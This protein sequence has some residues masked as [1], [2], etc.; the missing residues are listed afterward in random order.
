MIPRDFIYKYMFIYL[1]DF[2][3]GKI[4][5]YILGLYIVIPFY[6]QINDSSIVNMFITFSLILLTQPF[7]IENGLKKE[8]DRYKKYLR[9]KRIRAHRFKKSSLKKEEEKSNAKI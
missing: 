4:L 2:A 8:F 7:L 9:L 6:F 3:N 1:Y 5:L